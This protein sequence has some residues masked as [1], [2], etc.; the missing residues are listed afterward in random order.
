MA[1][2][3]VEQPFT[4]IQQALR[5]RGYKATMIDQDAQATNYDIVVVRNI[6]GFDNHRFEGSLVEV[7]G[8][9]LGEIL[10]EVEERLQR[11]GKIQGKANAEKSDSGGGFFAGLI[12]GAVIGSAAAFLFAPKSGKEMQTTVKEKL[13]SSDSSS[14]NGGSGKLSQVKEKATGF[15]N[16]AKEKATQATNQVK[17][18][19]SSGNSDSSNDG[20]GKLS[21]VKEKAAGLANQVK[22]KVSSSN[23]TQDF[24]R[25]DETTTAVPTTPSSIP[26]A[27]PS[28]PPTT[29]SPITPATPTTPV[30]PTIPQTDKKR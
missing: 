7:S 10:D 25:Q 18:K 22:D 11:A 28:T 8:R 21:Q 4:D 6:G 15:A 16:Q 19:V 3:A 26:S 29:D 1:K 14:D 5:T 2:I 27:T 12:S 24:N 17:E 13:S 9:T 30:S 23:D 20:G